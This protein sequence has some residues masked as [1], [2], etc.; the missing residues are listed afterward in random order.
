MGARDPDPVDVLTR[1]GGLLP[2][3]ELRAVCGARSVRRA[4]AEGRIVRV[5]RGRYALPVVAEAPTVAYR[6]GGVVSGLSA[7]Q[8]WGW[9]VKRP[10]SKPIV[11]VP[12]WR[13][14]AS[15]DRAGAHVKWGV[16]PADA[17][18]HGIVMTRVQTVIDCARTL[19]FDEALCVVDS[20]LRSG[21]VR[22]DQLLEV[23]HASPRTGRS[24]AVRV[25]EAGDRRAANPFE[26]CL[27]AVCLGVPGLRV[28]PQVPIA[29]IGRVDLADERLRLVLEADSIEF[30]NHPAAFRH[31]IRRYTALVRS[32][33]TVVRFCWEDVMAQQ[34]YVAE[35]LHDLVRLYAVRAARDIGDYRPSSV[36]QRL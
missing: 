11:T 29:G 23:A 33:W 7:A 4:H 30:H 17:V 35:V 31:D 28:R 16:V 32:G 27:R 10:P 15:E 24:K 36:D 19:P 34:D 6:L 18:H 1:A 9:E 12:P 14:R 21:T 22:R 5:A 8:A 13:R 2:F 3:A 26:S 20:A 25:V